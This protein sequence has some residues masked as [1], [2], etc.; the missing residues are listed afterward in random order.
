MYG[1]TYGVVMVM[2]G[3]IFH[4]LFCRVLIGGSYLVCLCSRV[5]LGNLSWQYVN[6][7]NWSVWTREWFI[8]I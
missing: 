7:M 2:T 3:F 8:G 5:C 1:S 4:P 6:S